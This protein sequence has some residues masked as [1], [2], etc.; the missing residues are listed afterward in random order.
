MSPLLRR[1]DT[2][3]PSNIDLFLGGGSGSSSGGSSGGGSASTFDTNKVNQVQTYFLD[4]SQPKLGQ[5]GAEGAAD[6]LEIL[7]QINTTR[8]LLT[9]STHKLKLG[10]KLKMQ[11]YNKVLIK[12]ATILCKPQL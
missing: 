2:K 8:C 4:P 10:D 11:M 6:L 3:N 12:P 1:G 9:F 5:G 7:T